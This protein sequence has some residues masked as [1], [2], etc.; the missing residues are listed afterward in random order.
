LTLKKRRGPERGII[1]FIVFCRESG[2]GGG[3]KLGSVHFWRG[4]LVE[5]EVKS[6]GTSP[7]TSRLPAGKTKKKKADHQRWGGGEFRCR[8]VCGEGCNKSFRGR[9]SGSKAS[10]G[11]P[12]S[13]EYWKRGGGLWDE[14]K[15]KGEKIT[16]GQKTTTYP[17]SQWRSSE[18]WK[19]LL[20]KAV[21]LGVKKKLPTRT[22]ENWEGGQNTTLLR[23]GE[24]LGHR[25]STP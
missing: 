10:P 8:G 18:R 6:T 9:E 4:A 2:R 7:S 11:S 24:C 19:S 5:R 21:K 12:P 1:R 3:K 15:V 22:P 25:R 20:I 23:E 13:A 16:R 17:D 14:A